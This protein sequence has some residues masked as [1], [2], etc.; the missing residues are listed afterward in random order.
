MTTIGQARDALQKAFFDILEPAPV[1]H[2]ARHA[3]VGDTAIIVDDVSGFVD[4]GIVLVSN[5]DG[6]QTQWDRWRVFSIDS[7]TSTIHL[8]T[9]DVKGAEKGVKKRTEAGIVA[10][11]RHE[12]RTR[13]LMNQ[14]LRVPVYNNYFACTQAIKEC[15]LGVSGTF[16]ESFTVLNGEKGSD[17]DFEDSPFWLRSTVVQTAREQQN[18]APIGRRKFQN[19]GSLLVQV[20]SALEMPESYRRC[21][22]WILFGGDGPVPDDFGRDVGLPTSVVVAD[23]LAQDLIR[24]FEAYADRGKISPEPLVIPRLPGD[25]DKDYD[26]KIFWPRMQE[27]GVQG[28]SFIVN[29]EVPFDFLQIG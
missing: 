21:L 26:I 17:S 29:V 15:G 7:D 10:Q 13:D 16:L 19:E 9:F 27:Q 18:M 23:C 11:L 6:N 3:S 8:G 12:Y 28:K 5:D 22:G 14:P 4:N 1:A 25:N 24:N 20:F 2:L